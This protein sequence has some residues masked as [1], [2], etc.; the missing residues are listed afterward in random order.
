[1]LFSGVAA[2]VRGG[3]VVASKEF[4]AKPLVAGIEVSVEHVFNGQSG[5]APSPGAEFLGKGFGSFGIAGLDGVGAFVE[6]GLRGCRPCLEFITRLGLSK[7][8]FCGRGHG[9]G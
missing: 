8:G 4:D 2:M 7:G 3:L 1:M 6:G 5:V 9:Y